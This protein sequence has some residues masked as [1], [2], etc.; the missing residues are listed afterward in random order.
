MR[1]M[2]AIMDFVGDALRGTARTVRRSPGFALG[3]VLTL[4]L[5]VGANAAMFGIVDRILLRPPVGIVDHE[6]VRLV[7]FVRTAS[8]GVGRLGRLPQHSLTYPDVL[9]LEHHSGLAGVAGYSGVSQVT[10]G[11]GSE[12]VSL[13]ARKVSHDF[14]EVLGAAPA[15][16]RFFTADEDRIGAPGTVVLG[17]EHWRGAHGADPGV[18]GRTLQIGGGAYT[19]IGV[20]PRGFTGVT[21]QPVDLWLPLEAAHAALTG[22]E[23]WHTSRN[24]WWLNAVARL[25]EGVALEAALQQATRIHL[26]A[27]G[28]DD[29][30]A[31]R[32]RNAEEAVLTPLM[33]SAASAEGR[34]AKWLL[35]VSAMVLLIACANVANLLLARGARRRREVAVRL[36]LGV[37]RARLVGQMSFEAVLL[38]ALGGGVALG[39]AYWGG[40]ALRRVLLPD[41]LFTEPL[42]LR[43]LAFTVGISLLA[44]LLAGVGPALQA[45]RAELAE[46]MGDRGRGNSA[47]RSRTRSLLVVAQAALSAVLLVGAGLFV[48]SLG[49][50]R[51][52]DLGL[53]TDRLL[54]GTL[55]FESANLSDDE[56][57]E[58]YRGAAER[59][60]RLPGVAGVSLTQS[61]F[62]WSFAGGLEVPGLDSLPR[63]PGGGPYYYAVDGDYF[64]T[65]GVEILEGRGFEAADEGGALVAVVSRLM[66]D[67]LWPGA[68]ALGQCLLV[69]EDPETCTTVVGVVE[70]AAR[71]ALQD[72]PFMAYYLPMSQ[73]GSP[74]R[75]LYVRASGDAEALAGQVALALRSFSPRVRFA[76]VRTLSEILDPQARSWKL[77][78][79]M[80]SVFGLLALIVAAVGLYSLL[81]F[82]VAERTR[83][84][85]IRIALGADGGRL[86][87]RVVRDASRLVLGGVLLGLGLAWLLAPSVGELLFQVSPRDLRVFAAVAA[88]L[89]TV[90]LGASLVP[91]RRATRVDPMVALRAE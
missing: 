71:S 52:L 57:T 58:L 19:V 3:V 47:V 37:S 75:G 87:T 49:E 1:R 10:V 31:E 26:A 89:T 86:L 38:A 34:V 51:R 18:L 40:E 85:G 88:L 72:E 42:G 7:G 79:T 81:A 83:E 56:T 13:R 90:A 23:D 82:N 76:R 50:V 48:Q 62:Q 36:A 41:V 12:A 73:S 25:G 64:A 77:G 16:G 35:G 30:R 53:E 84:L 5:G 74:A 60:R 28:N 15:V 69:G 78:A 43:V 29:S 91:G 68:T 59:A 70:D 6:E 65:V 33:A 46:G 63:M 44:G 21:L 54:M 14:F 61:P 80:F 22:T 55:E 4:G 2:G 27:G 20:A 45:S 67:T 11:S 39:L 9:D 8:E 17:F 24:W 66:A 32:A